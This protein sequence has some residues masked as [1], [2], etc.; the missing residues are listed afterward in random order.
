MHLVNTDVPAGFAD[1][2]KPQRI[3]A[4]L[5][6]GG[7]SLGS[8]LIIAEPEFVRF[9]EPEEA[10]KLLPV[11]LNPERLL[12]SLQASLK[13]NSDRICRDNSQTDCGFINPEYF[14]VIYDEERYRL[15]V[16]FSPELLP[17]QEALTDRYLPPASNSF[18]I[19]QNISGSW[20]GAQSD[21]VDSNTQ[22]TLSAT[23]IIGFG[24]SAIYG[25]WYTAN[26]IGT[27]V[28]SLHWE[29]D[30]RGKAYS[31]GLLQPKGNFSTFQSL[32]R[33]Y[34]FE[35][36]DSQYSRTDIGYQH[37]A[38]VEI[39]MPVRGRV[40]LYR[41]GRMI[42]SDLMEAG[43]HLLDTTTLPHGAYNIEIRI[44]DEAGRL[45]NNTTEFFTKDS[46]LPAPG[47]WRW[48]LQGGMPVKPEISS[49]MPDH[50]QQELLQGY[51]A[52]RLSKNFGV[53]ST[54]AAT[55]G[56]QFMEVGGRWVSSYLELSPSMARESNGLDAY[57]LQA[58]IKTPY[59]MLSAYRIKIDEQRNDVK[60]DR[61]TLLSNRLS[62]SSI[63]LRTPLFGGNLTLRRS[64][65]NRS[66]GNYTD[67]LS[68]DSQFSEAQELRTLE[69]RRNIFRGRKWQATANLAYSDADGEKYTLLSIELLQTNKNWQNSFNLRGERQ[70]GSGDNQYLEVQTRWR[71]ADRWAAEV[72]QEFTI[73]AT[74]EDYYLRS[75]SRLAGQYGFISSTISHSDVNNSRSTNYIGSFNTNII[76]TKEHIA[77]GG[78]R[79]LE[80]AIIVDIEGSQ[81]ENFEVLIDG[82]RQ[83]YAKGDSRSVI[84]LHPFKSY[85][86]SLRPLGDGFFRYRENTDQV[87]LYPGS[88]TTATYK[89]QPVYLTIG[90]VMAKGQG[91]DNV[92]IS[93]EG[94]S[95][96]TDSFGV[97]QLEIPLSDEPP[98]HL[99]VTWLDC[100]AKVEVVESSEDWLN[101]GVIDESSANCQISQTAKTNDTQ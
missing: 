41:D 66:P 9:V 55:E 56:Q 99:E 84:N 73:E 8:A 20:S 18:S 58:L 95:T 30:F 12:L 94:E 49:G 83:G 75:Y 50:Y 13:K 80:S 67:S 26:E 21:E 35:L 68:L 65:R 57:K 24:E 86:I 85:D 10:I 100:N 60:P 39:N 4:D 91:L 44:Y 23:S 1:L 88:V 48:S 98:S 3:V 43:N 101:L 74:P 5:Y 32:H 87:T 22:T 97:F 31:L 69:Y 63:S 52:R 15:D 82:S 61:Y 37:S 16:F 64:K 62:Q 53:F 51:I 92:L 2:T 38:L 19:V 27:R 14:A 93:I 25:D 40:E 46:Q 36:R 96:L 17:Q 79:S 7:R 34:G 45:I 11:S 54:L 47:E 89:I 81:R 76:A 29:R 33:L 78:E 70:Q 6:Y 72:N 28:S 90:R 42:H 71:D 59:A 77:W